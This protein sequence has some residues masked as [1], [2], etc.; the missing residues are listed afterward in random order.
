MTRGEWYSCLDPELEVLRAAA[1]EAVYIHNTAPPTDRRTIAPALRALF[2][3]AAPDAIV[4]APFHCSYGCNISLAEGV[5]LNAGCTI[6][7]SARVE[8]G[9]GSMLGPHVQIYCADHHRDPAERAEGFEIA[10]PVRIGAR[11]WI[12]GGAIL[13][14]GVTIGAGAIVGAGS[15]VTR[16]VAPGTTVAGSPA[17][18]IPS[19]S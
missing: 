7:D 6:L 4:E 18:T 2:A 5:Y 10:R 13:L 3:H 19:R 1:R 15:V 11:V 14:P 12:G 16:D 17:K 9:A 8:I